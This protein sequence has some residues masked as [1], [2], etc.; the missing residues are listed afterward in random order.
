SEND[1]EVH[2]GDLTDY[3]FVESVIDGFRPDTVIHYGEQPSAP[4]S[5]ID[6]R[7]ATY[8]QSNNV[9]GNLNVLFAIRDRSPETHLVKLGTMG[10][11]GTP[12]VD[13]E[14]GYLTVHQDGRSHTFLYP[15]T[16][17]SMYH[18][19]KVHDSH[20]IH[21]ATRI[22]GL[23]ATDLN[24][25]V[26]YGV[27][28]DESALD[29]RLATSFHY[30]EVF[31]T[32]LNRF[33]VQAVIGHPL[34][35]YGKGGQTRGALNIRDTLQCVELAVNNP[36]ELGD[37]R[38]F[39][40]FTEQFTVGGLAERVKEAAEQLGH[41]VEIQS[42]PNPRVEMEEHY[43]N[44]ANTKLRDLGLEPH[45]LGPELVQSM[46]RT[47]ERYRDRVIERAILPRTRWKPGELQ[48]QLEPSGTT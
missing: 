3:G 32:A 1:M 39:N 24:Q 6:V 21:F 30:D 18:L 25:G 10:E 40:Q 4:Y 9:V 44:A 23:R 8:T 7:H 35:V 48:A 5:M 2:V 19:S 43:Y 34:T 37:F 17:G 12:D 22:W 15:K 38:V 14:E 45:L 13:I 20:N 27:E 31:G 46:L 16:P 41:S 29:P 36:A 33:C 28:T 42:F 11:Y 47:I 26:V